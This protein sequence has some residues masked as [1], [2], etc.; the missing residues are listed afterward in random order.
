MASRTSR[1]STGWF[2]F[3]DAVEKYDNE[4]GTSGS[5]AEM[6]FASDAG[7]FGVE[8]E[9]GLG[10][11]GS[12]CVSGT[13]IPAPGLSVLKGH[14][15]FG[16]GREIPA[17]EM[18]ARLS[19]NFKTSLRMMEE[20]LED[21][22]IVDFLVNREPVNE[23]T[24]DDIYEALQVRVADAHTSE[25]AQDCAEEPSS[26]SSESVERLAASGRGGF[27]GA[28]AGAAKS[29]A[30]KMYRRAPTRG[31][32][33]G[34]HHSED[35]VYT[36]EMLRMVYC[37][38]GESELGTFFSVGPRNLCEI[39]I[40]RGRNETLSRYNRFAS[41]WDAEKLEYVQYT[42][43]WTSS[44]DLLVSMIRVD[45]NMSCVMGMLLKYLESDGLLPSKPIKWAVQISEQAMPRIIQLCPPSDP[46]AVRQLLSRVPQNFT[47]TV[48]VVDPDAKLRSVSTYSCRRTLTFLKGRHS[49]LK[50][51][52]LINLIE[53]QDLA[54][55][56]DFSSPNRQGNEVGTMSA[57]LFSTTEDEKD[58]DAGFRGDARS[59]ED[60]SSGSL[61]H[62]MSFEDLSKRLSEISMREETLANDDGLELANDVG[63]LLEQLPDLKVMGALS[64]MQKWR[65]SIFK[66]HNGLDQRGDDDETFTCQYCSFVFRKKYDMKRHIAAAHLH[67][68][69]FICPYCHCLFGRESNLKR[70]C[71]RKHATDKP[72]S[73]TLCQSRFSSK[74]RMEEHDCQVKAKK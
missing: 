22:V 64:A 2:G 60:T 66:F 73:C 13:K 56:S 51:Q 70:H 53:L 32:F 67:R 49:E 26:S 74:R 21:H 31:L 46:E 72:Y 63:F 36:V 55:D 62:M 47:W 34:R 48:S 52:A 35:D 41:K 28:A 29:A 71:I 27:L 11:S 3:V 58:R 1:H 24:A 6:D 43:I 45:Q 38:Y 33:G 4:F 18:D 5:V 40:M 59:G 69:D 68:K 39:A 42:F 19:D 30:S 16:P 17:A 15:S 44:D 65:S 54:R 8:P 37:K 9:P 23:L 10:D 12:P 20:L 50:R 14:H 57:S 7:D 61:H 25:A